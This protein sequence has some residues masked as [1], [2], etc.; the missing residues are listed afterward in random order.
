[1]EE[2]EKLGCKWVTCRR[3][4]TGD[5]LDDRLFPPLGAV[6]SGGALL[7]QKTRGQRNM[8]S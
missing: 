5:L 8:M 4:P 3:D 7:I 1:V 2:G 6:H